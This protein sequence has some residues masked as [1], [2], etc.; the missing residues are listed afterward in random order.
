MKLNEI[1]TDSAFDYAYLLKRI[2]PYIKPLMFRIIATFLLAIPLGLLDGVTAFALKPY[3]DVVVNGQTLDLHGYVLTR[4]FLAKIIPP[5]IVIFAGVQGILRYLNTYF[6]DWISLTIANN[7]KIDL[8]KK[9]IY[10]DSKFYDDNSFIS[11]FN[12]S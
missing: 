2:F 11:L 9:L 3:I 1:K 4:D 12:R 7:V 6:S 5:G 8:Y 10:L